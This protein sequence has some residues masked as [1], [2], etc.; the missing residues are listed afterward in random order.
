MIDLLQ[1][2]L[3]GGVRAGTPILYA[4]LGEIVSERAGVVNLGADGAMLMGA[5]V[6]FITMAH[7]QDPILGLLAAAAAGALISLIHAFM[8]VTLRANQIAS[9]LALTFLALGITSFIGR[10]YVKVA[11]DGIPQGAVPFLSDIPF[12]GPVFFRHDLLV[13]GA[14]LLALL[15]WFFLFYTRGGLVL[16]TV[17]E[18]SDVAFALGIRTRLVQ[19]LAVM[20]GGMCAGLAGAHLSLAYTRTWVEGMTN[21]RGIIA[22][23]LVIFSAWHPFWGVIGAILFGT[24]FAF[25]LQL[26]ARGITLSPYFLDML[27]YLFTLAALLVGAKMRKHAMPEGIKKVFEEVG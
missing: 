12:L 25:Q 19:Y 18:S 13:Y 5:C 8:V 24:T 9:G 16:R 22:V 21:G 11:I 4:M 14:Y 27:P 2:I 7:T 10:P 17:G 1:G 15:I 3:A 26:Q 6:G 23:A 20:F